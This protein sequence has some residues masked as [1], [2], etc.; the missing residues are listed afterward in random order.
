MTGKVNIQQNDGSIC[1]EMSFVVGLFTGALVGYML[2]SIVAGLVAGAL[3]MG[4]MELFHAHVVT[5]GK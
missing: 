1:A 4:L 5:K 3:F 2:G